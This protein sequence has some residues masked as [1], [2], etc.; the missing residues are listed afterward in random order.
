MQTI[1]AGVSGIGI[2][3]VISGYGVISRNFHVVAC[4]HFLSKPTMPH[5]TSSRVVTPGIS[6][7]DKCSNI[8]DGGIGQGQPA[9]F[10]SS[11]WY[12]CICICKQW[13]TT[14][15][16]NTNTLTCCAVTFFVLPA[17]FEEFSL[18]NLFLPTV[19]S[20][21]SN[22]LILAIPEGHGPFVCELCLR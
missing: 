18:V 21:F 2:T 9:Y 13:T 16:W 3:H 17:F 8:A 1:E 22:C 11:N 10:S 5:N 15:I 7:I 12:T 4:L 19:Y 20:N 14:C 6:S